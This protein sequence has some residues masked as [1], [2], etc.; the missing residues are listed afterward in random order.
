MKDL[1]L[2]TAALAYDRIIV[3]LDDKARGLFS[4]KKNKLGFVRGLTWANP[5][6][7]D[8]ALV[9]WLQQGAPQESAKQL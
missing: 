8:T 4:S 6:Q 5:A 2:V 3:S 1:P 9:D 7:S